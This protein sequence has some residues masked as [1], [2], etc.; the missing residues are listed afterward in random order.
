MDSA[1]HAFKETVSERSKLKNSAYHKKNGSAVTKLG[2]RHITNKEIEEKHGEVKEYQMW[3]FMTFNEFKELPKDLQIEYINTIEDKYDIGIKHIS[4]FL[5][6]VGDDGLR[7][8]LKNIGILAKCNP[9]KKRGKTGLDLF[10]QDIYN[11][12]YKEETATEVDANQTEETDIPIYTP[13]QFKS[14]SNE[15][16]I[17]YI[18]DIIDRYQIGLESISMLLFGMSKT[19]LYYTLHS[20]GISS[21]IHKMKP[22]SSQTYRSNR[23][24][25]KKDVENGRMRLQETTEHAET[26]HL[27]PKIE[28]HITKETLFTYE[29]FKKL[30]DDSKVRFMND[31]IT[32]YGVGCSTI[33]YY[34]FGLENRNTLWN[35]LKGQKLIGYVQSRNRGG[36]NPDGKQRF[37]A[38]LKAAR[39][40]I[41]RPVIAKVESVKETEKELEVKM[42][43][44]DPGKEL[45]F[46]ETKSMENT[47]PV[48][49]EEGIK[50]PSPVEEKANSEDSMRFHDLSVHSSYIC[51]G[52]DLDEFNALAMLFQNK[53]VKVMIDISAI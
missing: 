40:E 44:T 47:L 15:N 39:G 14:L 16:K 37:L 3:R 34:I 8:H 11:Q 46:K 53:R 52:L 19:W 50:E 22:V 24:L 9:D 27:T 28:F 49:M 17:R 25:F 20:V 18:N 42:E 41:E 10:Q 51:T 35:Y 23:E 5:F 29:E 7:W 12:K 30:P 31:V 32:S 38:D 43:L 2:N 6:H 45:I 36:D 33:A 26:E 13:A 4:N 1:V 48:V 21:D